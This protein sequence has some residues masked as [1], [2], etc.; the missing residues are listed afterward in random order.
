MWIISLGCTAMI[1]TLAARE[2]QRSGHSYVALACALSIPLA[3]LST[4]L[5]G[6]VKLLCER[7][8]IE[9]WIATFDEHWQEPKGHRLYQWCNYLWN[10]EFKR[11]DAEVY[12]E[13]SDRDWNDRLRATID[14]WVE[15]AIHAGDSA[16]G[17]V[18]AVV[19]VAWVK[20]YA[21]IARWTSK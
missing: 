5:A 7:A 3:L 12:R 15:N 2:Q 13:E 14:G 20:L 16:F 21:P 8:Q 4:W 1:V 10:V 6:Y 17:L 9:A 18:A 19:A 11:P